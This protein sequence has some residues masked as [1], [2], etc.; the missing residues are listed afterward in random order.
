MNIIKIYLTLTFVTLAAS[1]VPAANADT[2]SQT[3]TVEKAPL[4][5]MTETR[6]EV[7]TQTAPTTTI[8]RE[9]PTTVIQEEPIKKEKVVV[10]KHGSHLI[11]VGP[12]KVF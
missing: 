2:Y 7:R 4:A 6:E 1:T 11:K 12:V 3:R 8:I 9:Q 5:P 10:K